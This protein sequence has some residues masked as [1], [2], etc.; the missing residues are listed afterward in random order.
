MRNGKRKEIKKRDRKIDKYVK[1]NKRV[2]DESER[3]RN[4]MKKKRVRERGQ[5][6]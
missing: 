3:K 1:R 4:L 6:N 2:R 5:N